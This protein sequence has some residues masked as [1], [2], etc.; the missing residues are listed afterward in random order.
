MG[1]ERER[2]GVKAGSAE[3]EWTG[4][5]KRKRGKNSLLQREPGD[6]EW[7]ELVS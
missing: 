6:W 7:E 3:E 4:K 2:R 5:E 1:E